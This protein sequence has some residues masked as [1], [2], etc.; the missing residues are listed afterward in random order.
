MD[1]IETQKTCTTCGELLPMSM[2]YNNKSSKDGHVSRCKTCIKQAYQLNKEKARQYYIQH[3]DERLEY[4]R[5]YVKQHYESH[6]KKTNKWW[7]E[8]PYHQRAKKERRRYV[9]NNAEG[10]FTTEQWKECLL[11]FEGICAYSS[12]EFGEDLKERLSIDHIIPLD[13]GGSGYIW[14]IVPAKHKYNS[15]KRSEDMLQWYV[16]QPFYSED[17]VGKIYAWQQYAYEKWGNL[18]QQA[19]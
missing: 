9:K 7:R 17:R 14:N 4:S 19:V 12:E 1:T 13:K 11:F 6:L 8:H 18:K 5:Q 2:F 16:K 3:R 15:S 10:S